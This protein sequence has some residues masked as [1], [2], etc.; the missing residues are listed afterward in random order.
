MKKIIF[1]FAFA[2]LFSACKN[3]DPIE[4]TVDLSSELAAVGEDVIL[5]TYE[6]LDTKAG[7]LVT[8]LTTLENTPNAAP[9]PAGSWSTLNP[10]MASASFS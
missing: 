8:L 5:G 2:A 10:R 4:P 6:N 3:N 1:L 7:T 9:V